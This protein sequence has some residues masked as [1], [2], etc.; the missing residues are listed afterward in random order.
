[1]RVEATD[2]ELETLVARIDREDLDL[3]PEFQRGEVWSRAKKQRLIDSLL[4]GWHIPPIHVVQIIGS[5]KQE[6]LDGQ[7]RLTAIRDFVRDE[8]PVDGTYQPV[9]KEIAELNGLLFSELPE[10]W[11]RRVMQSTIRVF[12]IVDYLPD[13]PGELFFRLNQPTSL[14]SAEQRNA[15]I[16]PVRTQ[17]KEMVNLIEDVG[18]DKQVLG[19]SNS[20]MAYDDIVARVALT[21]SRESIATKITSNDLAA[22]YRL[23]KPLSQEITLCVSDAIKTLANAKSTLLNNVRFNKATLY[24][25]IIFIIRAT[26][27]SGGKFSSKHLSSFLPEFETAR[28]TYDLIGFSGE[29]AEIRERMFK[30]Y[31]SRSASRVADVSS[32]VMRDI[33]IWLEFY[34]FCKLN[35]KFRSDFPF[36]VV[37]FSDVRKIL[38]TIGSPFDEEA[39][40]RETLK[41]GWGEI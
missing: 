15:F 12:R 17:V 28:L 11:R 3:Q 22:L 24:S 1:M 9:E 13:E 29:D 33:A 41:V 30:A 10:P 21:V 26:R 40:V 16:G 6:V 14:T 5:S 27:R 23:S 34:Y 19:F 25:W 39:I 37:R 18:L 35:P 38:K 36:E 20:R 8:F 2:P 7:Q 4:R 31:E 32:V